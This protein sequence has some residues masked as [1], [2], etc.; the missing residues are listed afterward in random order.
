MTAEPEK[1]VGWFEHLRYY[2]GPEG[3][4]ARSFGFDTTGI[5]AFSEVLRPVRGTMSWRPA[6]AAR[7]DRRPEIRRK[8]ALRRASEELLA[9]PTCLAR[10]PAAFSPIPERLAQDE[11]VEWVDVAVRT[12]LTEIA[13]HCAS[14]REDLAMG[15]YDSSD[16]DY[17]I[18]RCTWFRQAFETVRALTEERELLLDLQLK[19]S[20]TNYD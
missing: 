16:Y 8:T 9:A 11:R 17:A 20:T 14:A 7:V 18:D 2:V 4:L 12:T 13:G 6:P 19:R 3:R 10:Y 1:W 5:H 15:S